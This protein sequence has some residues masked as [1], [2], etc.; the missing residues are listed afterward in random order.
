MVG[1]MVQN[2]QSLYSFTFNALT[3][4]HEYI[5]SHSTTEFTFKKY[6]YSHLPVYFLFTIIFAHIYELYP[7]HIQ[8]V[9]SIHI[10]DRNIQ[11]T[12]SAHHLCASVREDGLRRTD[13]GLRTRYKTWTGYKTRTQV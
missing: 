13:Y 3:D 2:L 10:H 1:E 4:I 8:R 12:F 6:I 11:S 7:F 5:Y 9:I